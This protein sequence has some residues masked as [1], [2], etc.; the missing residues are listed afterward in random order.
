MHA[1][2]GLAAST[3]FAL[4]ATGCNTY[5]TSRVSEDRGTRGF[6]FVFQKP[7]LITI[8]YEDNTT[9]NHFALIPTLYAVDAE[10]TAF[11]TT[12]AEFEN[13]ADAFPLKTKTELDQKIPENIAAIT[14]LLKELGV[15]VP[16]AKPVQPPGA[17][18]FKFLPDLTFDKS[19]KSVTV[20]SFESLKSCPAPAQ[21]R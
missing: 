4:C 13:T 11:G 7:Y 5:M 16:G 15:K 1:F 17:P 10:R 20:S 12:K 19:I 9:S 2:R 3:L 14:N 18:D 8:T 6:P 21:G